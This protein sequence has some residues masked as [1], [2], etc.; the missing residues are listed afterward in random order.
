M[1]QQPIRWQ[2]PQHTHTLDKHTDR[3]ANQIVVSIYHATT[4]DQVFAWPWERWNVFLHLTLVWFLSIKLGTGLKLY[5]TGD[6]PWIARL[7]EAQY[8]NGRKWIHIQMKVN[9]DFYIVALH[10]STCW[11]YCA[12]VLKRTSSNNQ[13][14]HKF[15]A[16]FSHQE[17][18]W[19]TS[20]CLLEHMELRCKELRI[21][22]R[23]SNVESYPRRKPLPIAAHP[24]RLEAVLDACK[25]VTGLLFH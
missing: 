23:Q 5:R 4:C 3:T 11:L 22:L 21:S 8:V 2:R 1:Q 6:L 7:Q 15:P 17:V 10:Y 12:S 18:R 16:C 13:H 9:R 20:A 14:T 25:V 19:N 24:W